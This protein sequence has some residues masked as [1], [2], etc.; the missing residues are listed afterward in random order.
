M[1]GQNDSTRT[2]S[3]TITDLETLLNESDRAHR[4]DSLNFLQM[5]LLKKDSITIAKRD[6]VIKKLELYIFDVRK[7]R[8]RYFNA[9]KSALRASRSKD[10]I[11]IATAAGGVIA[12]VSENLLYGS[13]GTGVVYLMQKIG[14]IRWKL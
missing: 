7:D 6:T 11:L 14:I 5:E 9:A 3:I 1:Q 2:H 10:Q 13:I 4:L 12:A 8:K